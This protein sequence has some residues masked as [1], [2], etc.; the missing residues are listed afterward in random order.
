MLTYQQT[1]D[2]LF[3][4]L[5]IFQRIGGAAYRSDLD[6]IK[7]LCNELGNPENKLDTIHVAGTNGKGSTSHMLASVLQSAG[8]TVGLYTSPHLKNFTERIK[9]NGQEIEHD[10]VIDFVEKVKTTITTISPSFFEVTVAMAFEYFAHKK[11]DIAIIEVGMGGRLDATNVISPL[12]SVITNI[13][14]DHQ[15]FLGDTLQ[16]IAAEKAGII[17]PNTPVIISQKQ[18]QITEVFEQIAEKNNAELIFATDNFEVTQ[19]IYSYN[20]DSK[21]DNFDVSS[22]TNH[23]IWKA[24]EYLY[25]YVEVELDLKGIYQKQNLAG[26]ICAL[27]KLK[28]IESQRRIEEEK[29]PYFEFTEENVMEGLKHA[30]Q[31]TG[32]K[33][34]W[35]KLSQE[36]QNPIIICDIAHNEDGINQVIT[37]LKQELAKPQLENQNYSTLRMVFGAVNDKDLNKIFE[38]LKTE[39]QQK[40]TQKIVFYFCKPNVPRG[41][42]ASILKDKAK[43]FD[44]EGQIYQSVRLALEAAKEDTKNENKNDFIFV[45]GS[46]FVVAEVV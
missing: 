44:L 37:Q 10:F 27:E 22:I 30:A 26:V 9:L 36:E 21:K 8:Y 24:K 11:V 41:L 7:I 18:K 12:L 1:L 4:Q 20:D 46:A 43:E 13:G 31:K 23:E 28:T 40:I 33:G 38:L 3:S 15:Q 45:G 35:Y 25:L 6:N 19:T 32:L 14:F 39:L 34:R 16:K 2:Y 5:P 17:K 29:N 42:E